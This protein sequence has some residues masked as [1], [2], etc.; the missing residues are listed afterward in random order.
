[1]DYFQGSEKY[2]TQDRTTAF[3]KVPQDKPW[4]QLLCLISTSQYSTHIA[5]PVYKYMFCF[6][7]NTIVYLER[8]MTKKKKKK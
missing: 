8:E 7:I 3:L 2:I 1:M 6:L 4:K 5:S